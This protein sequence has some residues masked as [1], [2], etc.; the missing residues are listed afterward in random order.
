MAAVDTTNLFTPTTLGAL[1]L[2][3]RVVMAPLTRSRADAMAV[4]A[5]FAADYYAQRAGAGLIVTEATQVSFEGMGYPRTPG[6]HTPE[7]IA[8]WREVVAAVH[9]KGGRIVVQLWH[10]GRIANKLNRGV[11]A[12]VVAPSA[13]RAPG[14]MYTDAAGMAEHDTPRALETSEIARIAGEFAAAARTA[15]DIGFDGVEVH[16]ANGYLLHQFLSSN[17]NQRS[18]RYGGSIENRARMPLEVLDA[19]IAA[20]GAERVGIR[21]SPGH[22]FNG[23][24]ETDLEALYAHYLPEIDKRG[25]AYVH[26]MRPTAN[27]MPF[28]VAA[29]ARRHTRSKLIVAGNYDG[30]TGAAAL[31]DLPAEAVAFGQAY[32]AN[33]DL[34]ERLRFGAPLATPDQSTFYTPGEKGYTDYPRAA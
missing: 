13:I 12:D 16:S 11:A 14:Q 34:A 31:R 22:Q 33:P 23:I 25:V 29:F 4:P 24:E 8:R 32:I 21:V 15:I 17:V 7:Q 20:I 26:V 18:D 10:V 19:V 27:T 5:P 28:D 9:A 1:H 30:A 2:E 3:N 6:L